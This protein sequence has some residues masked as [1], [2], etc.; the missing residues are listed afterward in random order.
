MCCWNC[1]FIIF[2]REIRERIIASNLFMTCFII[3]VDVTLDPDTAYPHL[4]ISADGKEVRYR[5]MD[6]NLSDNPT[7]FDEYLYILG[8]Q[9]FSSGQRGL[10]QGPGWRGDWL[11]CRDHQRVHRQERGIY[12]KS[13]VWI[14]DYSAEKW[15]W[16]LGK[17]GSLCFSLPR[18]EATKGGAVCGLRGRFIYPC[19]RQV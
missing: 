3:A 9:G 5:E 6:Q 15:G 17:R 13:T 8:K 1:I 19:I 11:A 2:H 12:T 7:R 16:D 10:L 14:L 18:G 4:I